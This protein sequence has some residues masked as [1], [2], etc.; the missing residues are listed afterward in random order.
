MVIEHGTVAGIY[1]D[2]YDRDGNLLDSNRSGSPMYFVA[3][4]AGTTTKLLEATLGM[5]QGQEKNIELNA[6]EAFGNHQEEKILSVN[7][8]EII[9]GQIA[10]GE[11]VYLKDG[12]EVKI[13]DSSTEQIII[14]TNHPL[15]GKDLRIKLI[16]DSVRQASLQEKA[17]GIANA[18]INNH[19]SCCGPE[20]CC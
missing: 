8:S 12:R 4:Y 16:V 11:I 10:G 2:T 20:G 5:R 13:L 1:Y 7:R 9:S 19:Q 18:S 6:S 14:D 17:T 15:S 3:G